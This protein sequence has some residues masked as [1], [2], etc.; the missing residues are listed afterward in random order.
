MNQ[1]LAN[2]RPCVIQAANLSVAWAHAFL[3]LEQTAG[4]ELI[5]LVVSIRGD[6]GVADEIPAVRTA[7]DARL[8]LYSKLHSSATTGNLIFP[9]QLWRRHHNQGRKEFFRRYREVIYPRLRRAHPQNA[10]GVYFQR[11]IA[12]GPNGIDQLSHI[13]DTWL[14]GNH[15]R[16]AQQVVIFDPAVDHSNT[17]YMQFPCLD[18]LAFAADRHGGVSLSAFYANHY[19]FDRAYGNYLGLWHLGAFVAG[20]LGLEMRQLTCVAGVAQL[21]TIDT[22][23]ARSLA[24]SISAALIPDEA[25][26]R[27]DEGGKS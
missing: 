27:S 11:M 20:E 18:Y 22:G 25:A 17:P 13:I 21:G 2:S 19:I 15:R 10:K 12:Y 16:S 4:R 7:L 3:A 24:E 9:E 6:K 23:A 14:G 26:Q 1:I 8:A 5:Q